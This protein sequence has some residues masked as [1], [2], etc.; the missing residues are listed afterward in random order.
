[1]TDATAP[2][3]PRDPLFHAIRQA[4]TAWDPPPADL[5]DTILIALATDDL[6]AQYELLTLVQRHD[7]LAGARGPGPDDTTAT[8]RTETDRVLIEFRS[9][10]LSV[11][12][13]VS[14]G[15]GGSHRLDGWVTPAASGRVTV[16]QGDSTATA[17]IDP[18][19]RFDLP[20]TR[21]G[22]TRLIVQPV[23]PETT[24]VEFR[25]T[26]FEI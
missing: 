17:A 10:E 20:V 25:T 15:E 21:H 13:R 2:R 16:I 12:V 8:A 1:M 14:H 9:G 18:T 26:L 22:L 11:L 5:A 23:A 6:D 19:G 3:D 4:W 7:R 24:P